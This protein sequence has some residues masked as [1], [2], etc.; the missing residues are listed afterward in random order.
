MLRIALH[1]VTLTAFMVHM[2]VGCCAHAH[3]GHGL[4]GEQPCHSSE[5]HSQHTHAG[6]CHSHHEDSTS[7]ESPADHRNDSEPCPHKDCEHAHCSFTIPSSPVSLTWLLGCC[8]LP[9]VEPTVRDCVA[10]PIQWRSKTSH[11]DASP[12][13]SALRCALLQSWQV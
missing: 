2:I 3:T 10:L 13:C 12:R 7:A 5:V 1:L 9:A 4:H 8:W 6:H 11:V